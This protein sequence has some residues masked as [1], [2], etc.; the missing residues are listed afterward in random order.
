MWYSCYSDIDDD[1]IRYD[2]CSAVMIIIAE[3]YLSI[4]ETD[5]STWY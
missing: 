4:F 5:Y 3:K 2:H 1:D